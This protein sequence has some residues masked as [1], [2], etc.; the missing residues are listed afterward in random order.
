MNNQ[1]TFG[2]NSI[3]SKEAKISAVYK[4]SDINKSELGYA[5]GNSNPDMNSLKFPKKGGDLITMLSTKKEALQEKLDG[6]EAQ[7]AA[8]KTQLAELGITF[9]T[10]NTG[11]DYD[12]ANYD[13]NTPQEVREL[14]Y[15]YN[16]YYACRSLENEIKTAQALIDNLD[17]KKTYTLS[18]PQLIS[19]QKAMEFDIEK[20]EGARGGHVIGHTKSGKP[21]YGNIHAS[22]HKNFTSKDHEDAALLHKNIKLKSTNKKT[23]DKHHLSQLAHEEEGLK[24]EKEENKEPDHS[25]LIH[26][27]SKRIAKEAGISHEEY[28]KMHPLTKMELSKNH[29]PVEKAMTTEST[30]GYETAKTTKELEKSEE[31]NDDAAFAKADTDEKKAKVKKVMDEWKAGT[32]KTSAGKEITDRKQAIAVALSEAGLSKSEGNDINKAFEILGL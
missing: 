18:T 2:K 6:I 1:Y 19:L 9:S 20:S 28:Q 21:V 3:A 29:P 12:R 8:I 23:Q 25:H 14:I 10:T 31:S 24:K 27:D 4:N 17:S 15:Q 11:D 26:T 30:P 32:L 7:K 5:F 16:D 22:E 13:Q